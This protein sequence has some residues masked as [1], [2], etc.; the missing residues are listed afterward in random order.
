[1]RES[2]DMLFSVVIP[3]FNEEKYIKKLLASLDK[4]DIGSRC[5][6]VVV[7]DNNSTDK[8][9]QVIWDYASTT[10]LNI[11][12]VHEYSPGV[13][14]ARN[15]GSRIASGEVIVFLDADNTLEENFLSRLENYI[16]S[17]QCLAGT[18][19]TLPDK[20]NM[21][22]WILFLSMEIIKTLSPRPFGKSFV[23]KHV[24]SSSRGFNEGIVLGENVEF[25]INIKKI[26]TGMGGMFG[27]IRPGIRCSLRRFEKVGYFRVLVPWLRA[28]LGNYA[29]KYK[30]MAEIDNR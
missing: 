29:I 18:I 16:T 13:S 2:R 1:M 8:T 11:R 12:M 25:L 23:E 27:H 15:S 4:Q 5:F 30:T 19:C 9:S 20:S 6:E 14:V 26:V 21:R 24:L 17:K 22:G 7:V 28:Y 3:C 10:T